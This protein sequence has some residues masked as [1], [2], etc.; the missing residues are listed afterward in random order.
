MKPSTRWFAVSLLILVAFAA[1]GV[2]A[3]AQEMTNLPTSG[4]GAQSLRP[5]WHVFIA[6]AIAIALILGWVVS[7]GRR[8]SSLESRIS[9]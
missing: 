6:Y 8:M 4:M 5:Y 1:G 9:E 7:I 2:D 3:A